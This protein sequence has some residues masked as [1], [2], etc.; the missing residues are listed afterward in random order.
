MYKKISIQFKSDWILFHR[1][2]AQLPTDVIAEKASSQFNGVKVM[3]KQLD[4]ITFTVE[5][6]DS[7]IVLT[8]KVNI[9]VSSL[10]K[11]IS[12]DK[13]D[14]LVSKLTE[15]EESEV[16]SQDKKGSKEESALKALLSTFTDDSKEDEV[17]IPAKEE[18]SEPKK[19]DDVSSIFA[20]M[21][22]KKEQAQQE[23]A[24]KERKNIDEVMA[25]I[26]ALAGFEEFKAL[27]NEIYKVAPVMLKN[28][29]LDALFFQSYLVAINNG[30]G[31]SSCLKL[32]AKLLNALG[33]CPLTSDSIIEKV[34]DIKKDTGAGAEMI[35]QLFSYD[36]GSKKIISIDISAY[37]SMLK[38]QE[39]KD[40]VKEISKI[41]DKAIVLFRIPYVDRE[42]VENVREALNDMLFVKVVPIA[43]F[44]ENELCEYATKRCKQ[45]GFNLTKS[46]NAFVKQR[47]AEEKSDG[48]FYGFKTIEKIVMELIYKKQLKNCDLEKPTFDIDENDA[49]LLVYHY[50]KEDLSGYEMLDKLVGTQSIKERINEI[51]SQIEFARKQKNVTAPCINMRFVGNPG[52]GKTTVARII[53]KILKE[54][55]VL[56]IGNFYEYAGRDFCGRYI[57]ETAPKTSSICR[58]AYGSVLFIDEAY[59][60]YRGEDNTRDFGVEALDTL[61]AEM[62]N[63]REDFVVI[64]AGYTDDMEKLMKGNAGLVGRMPYLLEFPNFTRAQLG[65][66]F[67]SMCQGKFEYEPELESACRDYFNSLPDSVINSKEF[68]NAR[69]VRNLFERTWAKSAIRCQL[70]KSAKIVLTK[71]DFDRSCQDKEFKTIF[72]KKAHL[73]F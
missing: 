49:S 53:G 69:F 55:G 30:C 52:T 15:D 48:K 66:I 18:D 3:D 14:T 21:A 51:V 13:F 72:E 22:K 38:S 35:K 59:S 36:S 63:H 20:K 41:L 25:E 45:L 58:D 31:L 8:K 2:D 12:E 61:I 4:S 37:M 57:G 71:D 10:F 70:E 19:T 64:M 65:D 11:G 46:A 33:V 5:T 28:K 39:F 27:C 9:F 47:I 62:E 6:K 68:S 16:A 32:F 73:G 26:N 7:D 42:I 56:S 60:L 40:F 24:E 43:P 34:V 54:K 67:M 50:L 1:L 29:T 17:P 44:T 23:Q